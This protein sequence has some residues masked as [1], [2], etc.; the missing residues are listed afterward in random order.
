MLGPRPPERVPHPTPNLGRCACPPTPCHPFHISHPSLVAPPL[1][2]MLVPLPPPVPHPQGTLRGFDQ[3]VNIIIEDSY[4]RVYSASAGVEQVPPQH[5]SP[6]KSCKEKQ[7]RKPFAWIASDRFI[8]YHLKKSRTAH[9]PDT[10]LNETGGT[11][12]GRHERRTMQ[13][14]CPVPW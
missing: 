14:P 11:I 13:T 8:S 7:F 6:S 12:A 2:P 10:H 9:S 5:H 4:E 3:C 1:P